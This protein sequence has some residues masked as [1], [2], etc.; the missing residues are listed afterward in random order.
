MDSVKVTVHTILDLKKIIGKGK[1]EISIPRGSS[2]REVLVVLVDTWGER[3]K[4]R[5]LESDNPVTTYPHIRLMVNGRDISFLRGLDT[6]LEPGDEILILP[7]VS[8]G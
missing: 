4:S 8:G 3:L 6:V 7:P 5:L 1:T 2:L